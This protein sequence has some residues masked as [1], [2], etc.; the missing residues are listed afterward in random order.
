M[1]K[2]SQHQKLSLFH[3]FPQDLNHQLNAKKPLKLPKKLKQT[4]HTLPK[5]W[6][7]FSKNLNPT[8][9]L[10]KPILNELATIQSKWW[11]RQELNLRP[12]RYERP[13]LTT[14]LL[15]HAWQILHQ[16]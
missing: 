1:N 9:A 2:K 13:A 16:N 10:K 7:N 4:P 5:E 15:S 12:K 3:H 6:L 14:E 11:E 8:N